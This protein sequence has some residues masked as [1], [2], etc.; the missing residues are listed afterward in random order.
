MANS[1]IVTMVNTQQRP[2]GLVL[3]LVVALGLVLGAIRIL[4]LDPVQAG[5]LQHGQF[6]CGESLI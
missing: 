1:P 5:P 4:V 3:G 2:T 6:E